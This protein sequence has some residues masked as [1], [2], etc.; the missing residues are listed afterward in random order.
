M[1]IGDEG[2]EWSGGNRGRGGKVSG[3]YSWRVIAIGCK[4]VK[5]SILGI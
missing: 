2:S 1:R 3:D 5:G 4:G